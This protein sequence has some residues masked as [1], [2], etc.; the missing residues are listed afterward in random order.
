[1]TTL[2]IAATGLLVY[3]TFAFCLALYQK[4]N[5]VADIAYGCGFFLLSWVTYSGGE[6]SLAGL[7]ATIFVTL[8]GLRLS[9]RI[10]LKNRNKPEDFRYRAWR[11]QWG[12]HV[13]LRSFLQ[14]FMLQGVIIF[15]IAT[16]VM[17]TN[18]YASGNVVSTV[19]WIG[20]AI[21][22]LGFYF[23]AVG[24]YQ[25]DAF[26]RR[27]ENKGHI[28]QHGLWKFTRHPNYFGESLMWWGISLIAFGTLFA[29]WG[30]PQT[31]I[32]FMS[33]LLITYLLL[34]VSGIP[35]LEAH[36]SGTEWEAYKKRTNAFIPWFPRKD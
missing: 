34:K 33:P 21:W 16:P 20:I 23:E 31:L 25:L 4:D 15:L 9:T 36:F 17:L 5:G 2:L 7:I 27:P 18:V 12:T 22:V 13:V 3:M 29:L 1:M 6:H 28:M 24:D 8:W 32:V 10:Y 26:R 30:Y 35:L 11:E 19:A 14:V